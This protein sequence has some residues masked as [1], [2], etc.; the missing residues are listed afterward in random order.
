MDR[1]YLRTEKMLVNAMLA[2]ISEKPFHAITIDDI[3]SRADVARKTFYSHYE[4]KQQLLW[5]SLEVQ[6]QSIVESTS[7]LDPD[8]LL[9]D[10]KPLSYPVFKHVHDNAVFYRGLLDEGGE[11]E[12]VLK[13]WDYLAQQSLHKHQTLR[14]AAKTVTLPPELTA[15]MLTGAL[16]GA[17]RWWLRTE[18][19][20]TPEQMAYRFSQLMA[21]GVL[22]SLGISEEN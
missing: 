22:Q 1:R 16:L 6:F 15:E 3:V 8:S 11:L 18:M 5:H 19:R 2:L 4:N 14:D 13:L 21:P 17:V 10:G 9:M 7:M 12:I 20:D